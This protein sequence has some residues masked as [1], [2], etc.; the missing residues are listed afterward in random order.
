[1]KFSDIDEVVARANNTDVSFTPPDLSTS[2]GAADGKTPRRHSPEFPLVRAGCRHLLEGPGQGPD[3][4]QAHP[5]RHYLD[6]LLRHLRCLA[7]VRWLQVFG[8]RP[9]A[10]RSWPGELFGVQDNGH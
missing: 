9:R 10:R 3:D 4:R 6:Q 8:H 2:T 7:A 1:M 5:R